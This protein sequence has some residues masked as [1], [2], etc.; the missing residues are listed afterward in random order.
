MHHVITIITPGK[1]VG[2]AYIC[3]DVFSCFHYRLVIKQNILIIVSINSDIPHPTHE[4]NIHHCFR[5]ADYL[6]NIL[7]KPLETGFFQDIA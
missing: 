4:N 7:T 1:Y 5:Q 2:K 6:V 3:S